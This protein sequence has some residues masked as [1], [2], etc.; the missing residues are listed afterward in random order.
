MRDL[1]LICRELPLNQLHL[2]NVVA[3]MNA[4]KLQ[5]SSCQIC[6][7]RPPD[8][9]SLHPHILEVIF[10]FVLAAQ[11]KDSLAHRHQTGNPIH[12]HTSG[13]LLHHVYH[14][15]PHLYR[16]WAY[17][18]DGLHHP[19]HHQRVHDH[20]G[21][22]DDQREDNDW[23]YSDDAGARLSHVGGFIALMWVPTS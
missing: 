21:E 19:R 15:H 3:F 4:N 18:S 13:D 1:D 22:H 9:A 5:K 2:D 7:E 11:P 14:H 23:L 10:L 12:F 16:I 17:I 8:E 20:K 6:S